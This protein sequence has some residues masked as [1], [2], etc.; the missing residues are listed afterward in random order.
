MNARSLFRS[1][2]GL[3]TVVVLIAGI[4][5][6]L[7][8]G[9]GESI[10]APADRAR[11]AP[12]ASRGWG[13]NVGFASRARLEEH[14]RK[15]SEEFGAI[16]REEYLR[17]A[18]ALRDAPADGAILEAVRRDGVVTRFDRKSGAFIA[19]NANGVIRTYFR[20]NDGE[21]YFRRQLERDH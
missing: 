16:T 6:T 7:V 13:A 5:A 10:F 20:P 21:R 19:F 15:H 3:A 9:W 1:P 12:Q 14:Y 2:W 18:Q 4:I 8:G 11:D 17:Q